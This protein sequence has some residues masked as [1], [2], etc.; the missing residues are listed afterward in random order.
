MQN[1]VK[2]GDTD[3]FPY[4]FEQHVF[5]DRPDLLQAALE[6]LHADFDAELAKNPPQNINTLAPVGYT[7]FRWATQ[8]DPL[9]NAY[10]LALV[11]E[12]GPEIEKARIP[13][14]EKSVFSYRF[15]QP[16]DNGAIWDQNVNWPSFMETCYEVAEKAANEAAAIAAETSARRKEAKKH[17]PKTAAE[18]ADP[19]PHV[20]LCDISDFYSRIYHHRVENALK[21]LNAKPDVVKR[22]VQI[23][24]VFSGTVSYGLPVGGPASRLLAELSLNSVNKLLRGDGIRF[25]RYV[26]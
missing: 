6:K 20:I 18:N 7:G 15:I 22:I 13:A 4:S 23:L 11:I 21:W 2:Y 5:H 17:A 1:I 24:Q 12:L 19:S 10:H 26:K 8:I 3:I 16:Q 14:S 9:W 25:C